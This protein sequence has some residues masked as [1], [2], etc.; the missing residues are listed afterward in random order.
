M[1][2]VFGL[3]I[4]AIAL[5]APANAALLV[6]DFAGTV[7]GD[8]SGAP[9]GST[10]TDFSGTGSLAAGPPTH[11]STG[12]LTATT[13]TNTFSFTAG[14]APVG[15][16]SLTVVSRRGLAT[17]F[18]IYSVSYS[19]NGGPSQDLITG[20]VPNDTYNPVVSN[21]IGVELLT[22]DT[23]TFTISSSLL[24]GSA[25]DI[26]FDSI[27]LGGAEVPEPASIAI[28]GLMGAGLAVRRF[29]RK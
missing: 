4:A 10:A 6:Y 23:I 2:R 28:F 21:P 9:T 25:T 11:W 12:N 20:T 1:V 14:G 8:V 7:A 13:V 24:T 3:L 29:R 5:M 15:L 19:I 22:G 18:P 16:S 17:G 27:S 26:R